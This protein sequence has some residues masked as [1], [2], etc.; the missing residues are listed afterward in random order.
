MIAFDPQAGLALP[1]RTYSW[2]LA[3]IAAE[4]FQTALDRF[5]LGVLVS[6]EPIPFGLFGQNV[7]LTT[8]AGEFVLRGAAHFDWQFPK[9]R[10]VASVLNSQTAVAVPWPYLLD[11]DESIFGWRHGYVLMPY[12]AGLQLADPDVRASLSFDEQRAIASALGRNL[13][14]MQQATSPF[15]GRYD[16]QRGVFRRF[17]QPFPTW[18]VAQIRRSVER[19]VSRGDIEVSDSDWIESRLAEA[20]DE[21]NVPFTPVLVHH[22]Y[23]E[24]N[25]TVRADDGVWKV[26]GVFDL[27][28]AFFGDGEMDLVRQLAAYVDRGE[29][30][31]AR[32]FLDGFRQGTPLRPGA[33]RRLG[34]YLIH[35][36]LSLWDYFHQPENI[37]QWWYGHT[38]VRQWLEQ[39]LA[40]LTRLL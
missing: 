23:K 12:L 15:A 8:S 5:G 40:A 9:E 29:D 32:S 35:D 38:E 19:C 20:W 34:V 16:H 28:E 13:P 7:R 30:G 1:P 18:I 2:R 24:A 33:L 26:S 31:L 4:Q 11:L 37:C 3:S 6:A 27:S 21:L 25:V 36:R 17:P 14:V 22:D 39:Y 10:L